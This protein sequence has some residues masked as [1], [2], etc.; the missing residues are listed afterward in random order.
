[1]GWLQDFPQSF[2]ACMG[3]FK[4]RSVSFDEFNLTIEGFWRSFGVVFVI[5]PFFLLIGYISTTFILTDPQIT[6]QARNDISFTPFKDIILLGILWI[7]WPLCALF[8]TRFLSL[9]HNY[10]RYIIAYN[11]CSLFLIIIQFIPLLL[12]HIAFIGHET[13]V[14]LALISYG[15]A[16]Y[17]AWY[18]A[19]CA[20]ETTISIALA[21]ALVD[22][23]IG[24]GISQGF[25][26]LFG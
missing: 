13:T 20:L 15:F 10:V 23:V 21:I 2:H 1:M 25:H 16:I 12:F 19:R 5:M 4:H 11:W 3:V 6:D 14:F 26:A 24:R 22:V 8:I 17:M 7:A 9:G 18:I